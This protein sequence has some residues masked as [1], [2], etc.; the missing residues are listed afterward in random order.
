MGKGP[1]FILTTKSYTTRRARST[2]A[3]VGGL[4]PPSAEYGQHS[5]HLSELGLESAT[6]TCQGASQRTPAPR[7]SAP[8]QTAA[9]KVCFRW[10]T[11][12]HS[13]S[14]HG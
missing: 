4:S 8:Q 1:K 7:G 10:E 3:G 6:Q 9:V 14:A 11:P 12:T 2:K 5:A 13:P